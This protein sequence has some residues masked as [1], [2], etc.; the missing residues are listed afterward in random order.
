MFRRSFSFSLL[1]PFALTAHAAEKHQDFDAISNAAARFLAEQLAGY[2]ERVSFQ[3][4]KLDNRLV[5]P[6]CAKLDVQ[7]PAGNRL[8]GNTSVKVKCDKGASWA[9]NLPVAISIQADYWVAARAL[10]NGYE[11]TEN[12]IEKRTGDLAQVPAG[13]VLD[14][15]QAIGRT[16]VGGVPAGAPLRTDALRAPY[17]V[18]VNEVVKVLA[19]GAGFEVA[20]E[21]RA[22]GNA[23]EGQSVRVKMAS[24]AVV[25]GTAHDGGMVEIK[26]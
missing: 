17:A 21:G 23:N 25:Q 5:L 3:L 24:G 22:M 14:Y 9:V 19:H 2:G 6:A 18:K 10:P 15:T 7:V 8:V 26:Y 16:I 13:A 11:V 20:S 12:D 1:L 4:G